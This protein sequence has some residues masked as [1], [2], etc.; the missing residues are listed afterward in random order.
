V[1]GA[2]K[3]RGAQLLRTH[4]GF[5]ISDAARTSRGTGWNLCGSVPPPNW[6]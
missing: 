4:S 6:V 5:D 2:L 1:D 3:G